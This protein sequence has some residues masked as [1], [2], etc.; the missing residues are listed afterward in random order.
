M[1]YASIVMTALGLSYAGMAALSLA[2]DRHHRQVYGC[3]APGRRRSMLRAAGSVLL[4]L[5]LLPCVLLW[6]AGA[7]C[8]AWLGVLTV[9]ALAAALQL[10]YWPR[11]AIPLAAFVGTLSLA[12]L[13]GLALG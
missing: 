2:I 6:G 1:A 11:S 10:P 7:G 12:R 5:A 3:D 8:V 4:I 13:A 9:G